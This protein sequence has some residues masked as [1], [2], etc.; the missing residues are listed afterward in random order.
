MVITVATIIT[1]AFFSVYMDGIMKSKVEEE[2]DDNEG[3]ESGCSCG[4]H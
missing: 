2:Q 4:N 3:H 1:L